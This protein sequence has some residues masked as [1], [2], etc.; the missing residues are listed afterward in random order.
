[1]WPQKSETRR[2]SRPE[3]RL[4]Q[5]EPNRAYTMQ[6]NLGAGFVAGG[7]T[8]AVVYA[9]Q[10]RMRGAIY[11]VFR[12]VS[13]NVALFFMAYEHMKS[14]AEANSSDDPMERFCKRTI[15]AG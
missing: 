1:M 15:C 13:P 7:I 11:P 6:T 9:M 4:R 5:V 14:L 2:T 8:S 12:E 10:N 3:I